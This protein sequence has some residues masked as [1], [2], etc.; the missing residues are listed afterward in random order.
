MH[1]LP[2]EAYGNDQTGGSGA[3]CG[4]VTIRSLEARAVGFGF[5]RARDHGAGAPGTVP[6]GVRVLPLE[7]ETPAGGGA[8]EGGAEAWQVGNRPNRHWRRRQTASA[9][10]SF[11]LSG[12][13]DAGVR[14]CACL[15]EGRR[16]HG[17]RSQCRT[18]QHLEG[19]F[20]CVTNELKG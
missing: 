6:Q 4:M 3:W 15:C 13:A 11:P 16:G 8:G 14:C 5:R 12:A 7:P 10:A 19:R 9:P 2:G 1:P 20:P 18:D 17:R